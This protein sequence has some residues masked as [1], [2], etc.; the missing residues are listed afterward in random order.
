M[1]SRD[2]LYLD[3]SIQE[4]E[5]QWLQI[6]ME[7]TKPHDSPAQK[8]A[9]FCSDRQSR[10]SSRYLDG[11]AGMQNIDISHDDYFSGSYIPLDDKATDRLVELAT[12]N[13]AMTVSPAG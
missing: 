4:L 1:F 12:R 2:E 13:I 10:R 9:M 8:K 7:E 3:R 5:W 11:Q 6:S